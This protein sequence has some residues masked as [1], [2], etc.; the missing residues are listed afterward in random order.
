MNRTIRIF[1]TPFELAETA[2]LDI[3]GMIRE[4]DERNALFTIA[5]S[6]GKTPGL[7]FSVL[8][9]HFG[10]SVN[11]KM[12]HFFW[13]DERCVPPDDAESNYGM[14]KSSLLG[15][16]NIPPANIH[17]M[18][19]EDDPA[20]EAVRYSG[21]MDQ[22]IEKRNGLPLFDLI[23]LGIGE[24]GHTASIF[25]G[26]EKLFSSRKICLTAVNPYTRQ[27]RLTITGRVINNAVRVIF[28]VTGQN[29]AA[30]VREIIENDG[31]IKPYPASYVIPVDGSVTWYLDREAG[32]GL[33]RG[34]AVN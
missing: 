15:M 25:P 12:V 29:K 24:D 10:G 21:E 18:R 16:I 23:I 13:V 33:G 8:A 4:A 19:G 1:Q 30:I 27:K 26:N 20:A 11:W 34:V 22:N 14:T 9:G 28:L 5:L 31:L 32:S 3:V 2:A 7:L 6:G 17:R